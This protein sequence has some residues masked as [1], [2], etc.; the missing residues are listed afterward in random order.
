MSRVTFLDVLGSSRGQAVGRSAGLP[1]LEIC[2][3]WLW[4][5]Q[6]ATKLTK[7]KYLKKKKHWW[8]KIL[9]NKKNFEEK[10]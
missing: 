6:M 4:E 5:Y 1:F 8:L 10:N 2:E 7:Q 9:L 3:R